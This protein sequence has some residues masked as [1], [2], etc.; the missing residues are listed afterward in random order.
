[1]DDRWNHVMSCQG[2]AYVD[3][4]NYEKTNVYGMRTCKQHVAKPKKQAHQKN[5]HLHTLT[6]VALPMYV[7]IFSI[8]PAANAQRN[9]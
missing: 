6:S 8:K 7:P 3:V 4:R 1:M 9:Q 5:K 2:V